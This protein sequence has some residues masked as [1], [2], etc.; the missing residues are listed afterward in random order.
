MPDG[1]IIILLV[2]LPREI[3]LIFTYYQKKILQVA[4]I[5]YSNLNIMVRC[6]RVQ[7]LC[8]VIL[9]SKIVRLNEPNSQQFEHGKVI[10]TLIRQLAHC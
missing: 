2:I 8:R 7:S 1:R 9:P 10:N 4:G 5:F 3:K 6:S